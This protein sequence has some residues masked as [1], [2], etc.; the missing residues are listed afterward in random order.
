MK[1]LFFLLCIVF[2]QS[3]LIEAQVEYLEVNSKILKEK[4]QIKLQLPRNYDEDNKKT[5]P[6]IFV[7]DGDYLFEPV[8]GMVDYLSYWEE[9]PDAFVVGINQAGSRL[10]DG[11]YDKK[12]FL[13]VGKGAQFFDF[14]QLEI[15]NYLKENYNIGDFSVAVGHDFMGNFMNLFL[16][17]ENYNFQGYINL[18]SDIPEGLMPYIKKKLKNSK[19]K[20][21]YSLTTGANDIPF[22]KEKTD[23]LYNLLK[24]VE[25]EQVSISYNSF[26]NTNHYT[27]VSYA[28]P[29]SL[30]KIFSPYTP[31]DDLEFENKLS[32]AE[33]PVDYLIDK[34]ELINSLYDVEK[35]IRISDIMKV[36]SIIE[37]KKNWDLYQDLSKIADSDHPNTLLSEYFKG[38]YFQE[39]GKPKKAI[40][41]YQSGY[42]FNEA[43][44]ITKDMLLDEADRLKDLFGY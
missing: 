43:G 3:Q 24:D 30:A 4:R 7:F 23:N 2:L 10:D 9:I 16:F 31:I 14:I 18:S 38:R 35:P 19:N 1:N 34:Y 26:E 13:P 25:N 5:Y 27:F 32:K 39:I 42:S 11:N 21:W 15:L 44:G 28:L 41:A 17:S 20:I 40:K 37:T 29:F 8:A 22:L 12:D 6:L 33:N 36:S